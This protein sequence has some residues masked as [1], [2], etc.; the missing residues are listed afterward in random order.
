MH[1][2]LWRSVRQNILA[3]SQLSEGHIRELLVPFERSLPVRRHIAAVIAARVQLI[4]AIFAVLVPLGSIVDVVVFDLSTAAYMIGLRLL[5]AAL[6]VT[7]AWP[8]ELP[9]ATAY[10]D[11]MAM[12]L[13]MLLVPPLFHLLSADQLRAAAH[14][15]TQLLLAQLYGYLPTVVL[16][17]L[18][19]FPLTALEIGLL[20]LP[21]IAAAGLA[22]AVQGIQFNLVEQ[23]GVL[24]F[25]LMMLGVAIFSG[26]SQCHYM[27]TLVHRAMHDV[28]TGAYTRQS[29]EEA[30]NLFFRLSSMSGK[31]LSVAFI[32]LDRFKSINDQYGH[33]AGDH[34]LHDMAERLQRSLRRSDLLIRWGGEEFLVVLPDTAPEQILHLFQRLRDSTLGLRP[35][36]TPLTASIGVASSAEPDIANAAALIATADRRMYTA[37]KHGRNTIVLPDGKP[38]LFMQAQ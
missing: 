36:G 38:M 12:L 33:E 7:L 5:A 16:G 11:A 2:K 9:A 23:G 25:M 3:P 1:S 4:A 14:T 10:R 30:L 22:F 37:K 35:D 29:G 17:G 8:R 34:A 19:I 13:A 32:D 20:A 24:W 15:E 28:L 31:S 6:F 26:M 18:A 27:A 21:V